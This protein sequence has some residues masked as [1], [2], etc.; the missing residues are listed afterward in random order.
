MRYM[1]LLPGAMNI[2][3][4]A[5]LWKNVDRPVLGAV[6][7]LVGIGLHVISDLGSLGWFAGLL[8]NLGAIIY[9]L[10][11]IGLRAF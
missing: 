9:L 6:W 11:R 5:V 7:C 3:L 2:L 1:L 4:L 8:M 10:F